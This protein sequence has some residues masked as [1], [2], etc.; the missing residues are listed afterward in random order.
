M[1]LKMFEFVIYLVDQYIC[2][3]GA[4]LIPYLL[5][6]ILAGVPVFLMEMSIGQV[7]Q[8][9]AVKAW[10]RIC[11]LFGGKVAMCMS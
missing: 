10:R 6:L 3:L 7:M 4:F 8:T 1:S 5:C 11:P 9:N 2:Y